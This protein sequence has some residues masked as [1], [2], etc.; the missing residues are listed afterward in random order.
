MVEEMRERVAINAVRD[1]FFSWYRQEIP[2]P[3][4]VEVYEEAKAVFIPPKVK[5]NASE[6][7][8]AKPPDASSG[9]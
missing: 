8:S 3:D 6:I 7:E 5:E 2:L 9:S 1:A 4:Y